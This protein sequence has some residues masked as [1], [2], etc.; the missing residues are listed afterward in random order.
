MRASRRRPAE[1]LPGTR[2]HIP[3]G[4]LPFPPV[5]PAPGSFRRTIGLL[6]KAYHLVGVIHN[7]V[8]RRRHS[9]GRRSL[10]TAQVRN[11]AGANPCRD[12]KA[13][14]GDLDVDDCLAIMYPGV[15]LHRISNCSG[16]GRQSHAFI[17]RI[18][19]ACGRCGRIRE[20]H[21]AR[22][23]DKT[24]RL[25]LCSG[26]MQREAAELG[27]V[28][29]LQRPVRA[30]QPEVRQDPSRHASRRVRQSDQN[31][32]LRHAWERED[33][34]RV[35]RRRGTSL[36][37]V[38]LGAAAIY[39]GGP[40]TEREDPSPAASKDTGRRRYAP[41]QV[42]VGVATSGLLVLAHRHFQRELSQ[43]LHVEDGAPACRRRR[44]QADGEL[45]TLELIRRRHRKPN[46]VHATVL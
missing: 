16:Q 44:P 5:L 41:N 38:Q 30:R 15:H 13:W 34:A 6:P 26:E 12:P 46:S 24:L 37:H 45:R 7:R 40:G 29:R 10:R 20:V 2:E 23:S 11:R 35:T 8:Q 28:D 17:G 18:R 1:H 33:V 9:Q 42:D 14:G 3:E 31:P 21:G 43:R 39:H 22:F 4:E 27:Q 19:A 36:P 25:P 32:L